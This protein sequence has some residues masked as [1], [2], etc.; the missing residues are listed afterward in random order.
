MRVETGYRGPLSE[1]VALERS[2]DAPTFETSSHKPVHYV[3]IVD[4]EQVLGFLWFVDSP[5]AASFA[6]RKAAGGLANNAGVAWRKELLMLGNAGMTPSQAVAALS[7]GPGLGMYG[8]VRSAPP[9]V[10]S[11]SAELK[12]MAASIG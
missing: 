5:P 3:T 10:A 8:R 1:D 4:D 6:V 7:S 9:A 11:G 12:Q 2:G